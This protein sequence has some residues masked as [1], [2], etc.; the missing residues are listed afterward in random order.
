MKSIAPQ[1]IPENNRPG[2]G[3]VEGLVL[4]ALFGLLW[5]TLHFGK[6]MLVGFDPA[7]VAELDFSTDQIPYYADRTLLR[8][9]IAFS[10]SLLAFLCYFAGLSGRQEPGRA[11]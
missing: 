11:R 1:L 2:F 3:W 7:H 6:G 8:M 5:C 9:W 4:L 10:F